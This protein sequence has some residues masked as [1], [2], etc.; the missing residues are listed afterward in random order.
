MIPAILPAAPASTTRAKPVAFEIPL[1][2]LRVGG[3]SKRSLP[4]LAVAEEMR[5]KMAQT[6]ELLKVGGG[7]LV[8][9]AVSS[10]GGLSRSS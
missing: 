3:L 2:D 6:G 5:V 4:Q 10:L 1:D 8:L 9:C 7:G